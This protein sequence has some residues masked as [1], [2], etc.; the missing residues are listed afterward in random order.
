MYCAI[1]VKKRNDCN[2]RKLNTATKY[3]KCTSA[4]LCCQRPMRPA[5]LIRRCGCRCADLDPPS[6]HQAAGAAGGCDWRTAAAGPAAAAAATLAAAAAESKSAAVALESRYYVL[7]SLRTKCSKGAQNTVKKMLTV[8][9]RLRTS[10][11]SFDTA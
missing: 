8:K 5:R 4:R 7:R 6:P 11:F 2:F 10:V 1:I 9:P 3:F